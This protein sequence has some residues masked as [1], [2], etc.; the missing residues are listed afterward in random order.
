MSKEQTAT[1]WQTFNNLVY[2]L[3]IYNFTTGLFENFIFLINQINKKKNNYFDNYTDMYVDDFDILIDCENNFRME[4][5]NEE[6]FTFQFIN[7]RICIILHIGTK[8]SINC[9]YI[10]NYPEE[11]IPF[12]LEI[13]KLFFQNLKFTENSGLIQIWNLNQIHMHFIQYLFL[14]IRN[15]QNDDFN[16]EKYENSDVSDRKENEFSYSIKRKIR[17]MAKNCCESCGEYTANGEIDHI[18]EH[19]F[20]GTNNLEDGQYICHVCHAKKSAINRL[21]KRTK[22]HM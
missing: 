3:Y 22:V 2:L 4:D 17:E 21:I 18:N 20:G 19:Q 15:F 7:N 14:I 11:V 16:F 12:L 10:K 13:L 5:G 6:Y 9:G 1:N 8:T